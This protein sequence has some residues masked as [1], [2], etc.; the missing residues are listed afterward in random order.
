MR[1]RPCSQWWGSLLPIVLMIIL[2]YLEARTP[3]PASVRMAAQMAITVLGLGLLHRWA[4]THPHLFL[5][6]PGGRTI[7]S[8]GSRRRRPEPLPPE[9]SAS[10]RLGQ[11]DR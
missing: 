1:K 2:L 4:R 5:E 3:H 6:D 11:D 10:G 9:G 8:S 7:P